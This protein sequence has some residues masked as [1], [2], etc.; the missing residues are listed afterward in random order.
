MDPNR[1]RQGSGVRETA[2]TV[3]AV[4]GAA[5]LAV[6]VLA[7]LGW[8]QALLDWV[9]GDA[10]RV[11]LVATAVVID[12]ALI[13]SLIGLSSREPEYRAVSV[14]RDARGSDPRR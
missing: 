12:M 11:A 13:L 8:N 2:R 6:T 14:R 5:L 4:T 7:V 3:T 9:G 10:G 1:S